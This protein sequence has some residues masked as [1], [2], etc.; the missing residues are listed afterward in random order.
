MK[1]VVVIPTYNERA[2]IELLIQALEN[3]FISIDHHMAILVVDDNSPDGTGDCVRALMRTHANLYL[4]TGEKRGLGAAMTRGIQYALGELQAEAIIEMDADFS[5]QPQDVPRLMAALE[6]GE[7]FVIGSRYIK[8]GSIPDNWG[9][10][11]K[12]ISKWG[13]ICA[14]YLA[15]LYRVRDCTAGFRAIRASLLRRIDFRNLKVQGYAFQIVLLNQAMLHHAALREIPVEFI[16]RKQGAT[17]LGL[18]DIIEF[19]INVWWIRLQTSWTLLKFALVGLLGVLVNLF[20]FIFLLRIGINKFIAS[21]IAIELSIINNFLL[22][23]YWTFKRKNSSDNLLLKGLKFKSVSLLA[24]AIS[25]TTFLLLSFAFPK[26]QPAIQQAIAI[27]PATLV[28]YFLNS[29]WTFKD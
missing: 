1:I 7:D 28:N 21:P 27:V 13:N 2:N 26:G 17:K 20:F 16:D 6:A 14:R 29:Y 25:Y 9:R 8:G 4:L 23:N 22:N 19:L 15:G 3:Q 11:R 10:L 5:H 18:G 24:L 12:L